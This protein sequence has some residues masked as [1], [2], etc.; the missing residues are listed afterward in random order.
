MYSKQGFEV[1]RVLGGKCK[2][3]L[4]SFNLEASH[5]YIAIRMHIMFN[6]THI[7]GS[8]NYIAKRINF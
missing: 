5:V 1:I 3:L 2:K 4:P 7:T 8:C 6:P